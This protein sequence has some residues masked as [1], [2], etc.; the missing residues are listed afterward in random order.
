LA[1]TKQAGTATR[2]HRGID[3]RVDALH[4]NLGFSGVEVSLSPR[5]FRWRLLGTEYSSRLIVQ[6]GGGG[7]ITLGARRIPLDN[8][9]CQ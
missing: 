3:I 6:T 9:I 2:A 8:S 7:Y 4:E 5:M 1:T